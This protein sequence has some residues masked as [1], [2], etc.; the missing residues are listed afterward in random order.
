MVIA[1]LSWLGYLLAAFRLDFYS[2]AQ[3][4]THFLILFAVLFVLYFAVI[5]HKGWMQAASGHVF[6]VLGSAALFRLTLVFAGLPHDA[7]FSAALTDIRGE[8]VVFERFL[9]YDHDIWRYLW[10][11]HI[12]AAGHDPY[13]VT[14]AEWEERYLA[15]D[16][17]AEALFAQEPWEDIHAFVD[18]RS[19]TTVY[20]PL[21]QGFFRLSHWLSPGSVLVMK[22]LIALMDIAVCVVLAAILRAMGKPLSLVLIYAW[23]PLVIKEYAGSGHL[24]PLM[25]MFLAGAFYLVVSHRKRWALICFGLA[26]S[27]KLTPAVLAP[28]FMRRASWKIWPFA[29]L[30]V[31]AGYVF[32]MDSLVQ[33]AAGLGAF[34]RDW[35]FNTGPWAVFRW[36][37]ESLGLPRQTASLLS[38]FCLLTVLA[39][40]VRKDRGDHDHLLRGSFFVLATLLLTSP[41]VMPWY[42]PWAL[43]LAVPIGIR[44]WAAFTFLSL[45]SYLI[46]ID[47]TERV[48]WLWLEYGAFFSI[49]AFLHFRER[50][51]RYNSENPS[52]R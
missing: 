8:E 35:Q 33:M 22:L 5:L 16:E 12:S 46:Y 21:A 38:A 3:D 17:Q 32:Y 11:G 42:L 7:P 23:N 39:W 41:A 31:L 30:P 49:L 25:L 15:G 1:G 24:D 20:P 6:L 40:W 47:Q 19:Y 34:A 4:V 26:V 13:A 27:A 44:S 18:Y 29:A 10:D 52:G 36:F 45:L 50:T 51:G 14:P 48:W 43:L 2:S 28:F 9:I 37:S